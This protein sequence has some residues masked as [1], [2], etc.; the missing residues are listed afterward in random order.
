MFS[1]NKWGECDDKMAYDTTVKNCI[2]VSKP[3]SNS[4]IKCLYAMP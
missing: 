1:K 3:I 4:L 2:A